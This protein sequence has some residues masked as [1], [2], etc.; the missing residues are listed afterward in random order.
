MHGWSVVLGTAGARQRRLL[1]A[2][3]LLALLVAAAP[4]GATVSPGGRAYERVSP[5]DKFGGQ[6][7]GAVDVADYAYVTPDG[8]GVFFRAAGAP[9]TGATRGIQ[10]YAVARRT[11]TGWS[12]K[13]P[14]PLP[15]SGPIN[16]VDYKVNSPWPSDNLE[17]IAF[18]TGGGG[19]VPG[20][21]QVPHIGGFPEAVGLYRTNS[22]GPLTW[23]SEPT[24]SAPVPAVGSIAELPFMPSGGSPDLSTTYFAYY[25]TLVAEDAPRTPNVDPLSRL[26]SAWGFYRYANGR[27]EAA[28]VLPDGTTDPFGAVPAGTASAPNQTA[29]MMHPDDFHNQVSADGTRALFVSPDPNAGSG[30]PPQVYLRKN[31]TT[32]VLV[33]RSALT[34]E[35]APSGAAPQ[36]RLATL[37]GSQGF[38]YA[39]GARDGS[40]VYFQSTDQLTADAPDDGT[41][42]AYVFDVA[43][44]STTY[45][46]GVQGEVI[47]A[48]DDLSRFLYASAVNPSILVGPLGVW[49]DGHATTIATRDQPVVA[50]ESNF[51][52]Q[53]WIEDGR[54]TADGSSFVFQSNSPLPGGFNN[55][56]GWEE[57]YRYETA[58]G[59]LECLSCAPEGQT[60]TSNSHLS[61]NGQTPPMNDLNGQ[62][63]ATRAMSSDGK[64][65]FFATENALV[66]RDTNGMR[67]VY[68]WEDGKVQLI[69]TGR[70]QY[71][72]YLLDTS[73]SGDD[74]FIATR[75]GLAGDDRDGAF[76]VYDA[77][78]GEG[79][80]AEPAKP[81]CVS[82]CRPPSDAAPAMPSAATVTFTGAG[83]LAGL[84][85]VV[86]PAAK[87]VVGKHT[88][89]GHTVTLTV[90][91][92]RVGTLS[93][94]GA[95]LRTAHRVV[96]KAGSYQLEGHADQERRPHAGAQRQ[97]ADQDPCSLPAAERYRRFE[98]DLADREGVGAMTTSM[99]SNDMNVPTIHRLDI[100]ALAVAVLTVIALVIAGQAPARADFGLQPGS[101]TFTDTNMKAGGHG[102]VTTTFAVNRLPGSGEP[103]GNLKSL[104]VNLPPGMV[105]NAQTTPQCNITRVQEGFTGAFCPLS[106]AVGYAVVHIAYPGSGG[107][108]GDQ[109]A[110]IYNITP[111][112]GE[113]AAFGFAVYNATVRLSAGV[114]SDYR[115]RM[116]GQNITEMVQTMRGTVVFWGVP[117]D[118]T[119]P[120][121]LMDINTYRMF[122][123]PSS[124]QLRLPFLSNPT[125]CGADP[126][127]A[128][129]SVTSWQNP[130]VTV[131]HDS[132]LGPFTNCAEVPFEPA[133]AVR[134]DSATAGVPASYTTELD[135][136]TEPE[137][138]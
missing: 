86:A 96:T 111:D 15:P 108:G 7:G 34:G 75:E 43:A 90:R 89:R 103:D 101:F 20:N 121:A 17:S 109:T 82:N 99:E 19:L 31:G 9:F 3:A 126:L 117:A 24:I 81:E 134:S 136:A 119:G 32:T 76:D 131:S 38:S 70:S 68:E 36:K 92:P 88:V 6:A 138:G 39:Y 57:V 47:A 10:D 67:D 37:S 113:P 112:D 73:A 42:K 116:T 104:S 16:F 35:A 98:V 114:G 110:L 8:K 97:V 135:S 28:G 11:A 50:V 72:S 60:P 71:H 133:I 51:R 2:T 61:D 87:L 1:S 64:R 4:A 26:T 95:G 120:G 137:P 55:S 130:G 77:R 56:S 33:S 124:E 127:P 79:F 41:K 21:P 66:E 25:G 100:R 65:V 44:E 80:P 29:N 69:S 78:I 53:A 128:V 74:V 30:R 40:R 107:V 13:N 62:L 106:S 122:D 49:A 83:D 45:L 105:G 115:V 14:F 22:D 118:H 59:K 84:P 102:D 23:L 58:S 93:A 91:A 123:G 46:P 5:N 63:R 52:R 48:S 54:T 125:A 12:V 18:M 94:S 27:V 132:V 129:M 85:S